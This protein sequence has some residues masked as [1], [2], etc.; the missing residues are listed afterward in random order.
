M[1]SIVSPFSDPVHS[2][3]FQIDEILS[4]SQFNFSSFTACKFQPHADLNGDCSLRLARERVF[5]LLVNVCQLF[6]VPVSLGKHYPKDAMSAP[7]PPEETRKENVEAE[8]AENQS[9]A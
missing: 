6:R 7:R 5:N 9:E 1:K 8:P 3:S 4:S 2:P